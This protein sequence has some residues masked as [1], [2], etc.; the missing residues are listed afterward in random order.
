MRKL[1]LVDII[2]EL[3][4][5]SRVR[6]S[7][8]KQG[9]RLSAYSSDLNASL[10]SLLRKSSSYEPVEQNLLVY[11]VNENPKNDIIIRTRQ[12]DQ[13][14]NW[15]KDYLIKR[16]TGITINDDSILVSR[17]GDDNDDLF[18]LGRH[19][20]ANISKGI[21]G[22]FSSDG[23]WELWNGFDRASQSADDNVV[24]KKNTDVFR[25]KH[26]L[27]LLGRPI[28][29]DNNTFNGSTIHYPTL[30]HI[31]DKVRCWSN[32][33]ELTIKEAKLDYQVDILYGTDNQTMYLKPEYLLDNGRLVPDFTLFSFIGE[34]QNFPDHL[35]TTERIKLIREKLSVLVL[36]EDYDKRQRMIDDYCQEHVFHNEANQRQLH[37]FLVSFSDHI[38]RPYYRLLS[39]NG[40]VH[41]IKVEPKMEMLCWV[42]PLA[43]FGN[44]ISF[45]LENMVISVPRSQ[46]F[47]HLQLYKQQM[48]EVNINLVFGS[49]T[50]ETV[51]WDVEIDA[52]MGNSWFKPEMKVLSQG[53]EVDR[54][55]WRLALKDSW[56]FETD[57][58]VQILDEET[59]NKLR[60]LIRIMPYHEK[61]RRKEKEYSRL[62]L[63]DWFMVRDQ[64][65][66]IRIRQQDRF[67]L[68][69]LLNFKANRDVKLPKYLVG[70]PRQ[71]QKDGYE[72]LLFLYQY[73]F[74]AILA[75]DM[76]LGKT[77]QA[78]MLMAAIKEGIIKK[79]TEH[80]FLIVVPPSLM[81][82]WVQELEKFYPDF[83]VYSYSG[84]ERRRK[85]K[86]YDIILVTY[87]LI[88]RDLDFLQQNEFDMVVVDEAQM[89]KNVQ[90][91]RTLALKQLKGYFILGITGTPLENHLGEYYSILDLVLPGLLGTY[92][93]FQSFMKENTLDLLLF[94]TRP[95]VLRR[96]KSTIHKEL[97]PKLE[98]NVY[99]VLSD[100]QKKY[101]KVIL[102]EVK[103][104]IDSAYSEYNSN[105]ARVIALT[106]LLRL[107]Q[108]CVSP[109]LLGFSGH[110]LSPK[111][112]YLVDHLTELREENHSALVFSQFTT[113]LDLMEPFLNKA[114][115][116]FIRLDGKTPMTKRQE[117]VEQF[118][119]SERPTVFLMSLKAGGVGLNLTRASYVF[120][121]DPWWNPAVETQASDRAHRIGQDKSVMITRLIMHDTI[122]ER[123]MTLKQQKETLFQAVLGEEA[124]KKSDLKFTREDI[125]YLLSV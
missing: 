29:I 60:S 38:E 68:E 36:E 59:Y 85:F 61:N 87:D 114:E 89:V 69:R 3:G 117:L 91:A 109:G 64:G 113:A 81:F 20:V 92:P 124:M 51:S 25:H 15:D 48:E 5:F 76:G 9:K 120:H 86:G 99:L 8:A 115:I 118:Q 78:I 104:T 46:F 116:D 79:H 4:P 112:S 40:N 57:S 98:N 66:R 37:R 74:G 96:M 70:T 63:L 41:S 71:Y 49:K 119:K 83:K 14:L 122:E 27:E 47:R 107:R 55:Q 121:V 43:V 53:E 125:D 88:R 24:K 10:R 80:P 108:L 31:R 42:I 7:A 2:I 90:A 54:T 35:K 123:L 18:L 39:D 1:E 30:D 13:V 28:S 84:R 26:V 67:I 34:L 16:F 33:Q 95:F 50:I 17:M 22:R 111:F 101:Y 102:D 32:N 94:R 23:D 6:V 105:Q 58:T 65:I 75:D 62:Q 44:Q 82:N 103:A 93:E 72:W 11:L 52:V 100:D 12:G 19:L 97:P 45:D 21:I 106:A 56:M 110:E 73:R 77:L